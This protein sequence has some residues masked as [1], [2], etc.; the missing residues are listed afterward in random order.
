M[1]SKSSL[2]VHNGGSSNCAGS[3]NL[4]ITW[5]EL[6]MPCLSCILTTLVSESKKTEPK[7]TRSNCEKFVKHFDYMV[8]KTISLQNLVLRD[9]VQKKSLKHLQVRDQMLV[10]LG[11][12]RFF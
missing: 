8:R 5:S 6:T 11:R 1:E 12:G 10:L 7:T 2:G 9:Y 4:L 3:E